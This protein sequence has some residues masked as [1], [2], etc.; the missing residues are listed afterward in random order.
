M[1]KTVSAVLAAMLCLSLTA[2]SSG[3][4]KPE[5]KP[6]ASDTSKAEDDPN[7]SEI[8]EEAL[9]STDLEMLSD[10]KTKFDKPEHDASN[11]PFADC[12]VDTDL[13]FGVRDAA[14]QVFEGD[15]GML[16]EGFAL[17]GTVD[18]QYEKMR[19]AWISKTCETYEVSTSDGTYKFNHA[20]EIKAPKEVDED[21]WFGACYNGTNTETGETLGECR[22][23][24]VAGEHAIGEVSSEQPTDENSLNT[25]FLTV[26]AAEAMIG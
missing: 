12:E 7:W 5:A 26:L 21:A 8:A 9:V 20:K 25:F 15:P 22:I 3:T 2:C 17:E 10:H 16:G 14:Y 6:T 4:E 11:A 23:I 13:H 19:K 18:E 24:Y 1:R